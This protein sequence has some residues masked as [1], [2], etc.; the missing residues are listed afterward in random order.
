MVLLMDLENVC[1]I[2]TTSIQIVEMMW[3]V[4]PALS[5][6]PPA[7]APPLPIATLAEMA[8]LL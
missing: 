5:T 2:Q 6:E 4:Y 1:E 8:M 3:P 7:V